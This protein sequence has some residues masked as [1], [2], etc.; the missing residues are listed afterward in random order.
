MKRKSVS[1]NRML[2]GIT[3]AAL[4]VASGIAVGDETLRAGD[5]LS[6]DKWYGRAGG[7]I[8]SDRVMTIGKSSAGRIGITYDA[9]V[10]KRTNMSRDGAAN[11]S[12]GITYDKDVA[13]RTNMQRDLPPTQ[14]ASK[15]AAPQN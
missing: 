13:E 7:L 5:P 2:L 14:S 6:M 12:V 15:P 8:G 1:T 11:G 3:F 4:S 9:D 10:A